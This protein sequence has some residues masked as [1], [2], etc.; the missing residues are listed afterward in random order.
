MRIFAC[1]SV[2][3]LAAFSA[4]PSGRAQQAPAPAGVSETIT[5]RMS[6]FAFDPEYLRLKAG[7]PV[8]FRFLN[9]SRGGHDFSAPAFFAASSTLPGSSAPPNGDVAV[10]AHQ[11]VEIVVVPLKPG[12]YPLKCT[13][14]LHSFFGMHGTVEV[15]P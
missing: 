4:P 13:H 10:G 12:T 15:I 1:G 11:T 6:N 8:R 9:E 7:V 14:F 2:I 3:V 5:V